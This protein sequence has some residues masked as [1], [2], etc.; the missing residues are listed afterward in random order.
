VSGFLSQCVRQFFWISL[1][2]IF[3]FLIHSFKEAQAIL[4]TPGDLSY[5]VGPVIL[6]GHQMK[7]L[8]GVNLDTINVYASDS[9]GQIRQIPF[10]IDER[11][12]GGAY[13][14][15]ANKIKGTGKISKKD[16]LVF[17]AR[18]AGPKVS[19]ENF[20]FSSRFVQEVELKDLGTGKRAWVY[21]VSTHLPTIHTPIHYIQYDPVENQ[22]MGRTYYL[23]YSRSMQNPSKPY[24]QASHQAFA[25][26]EEGQTDIH[27]SYSSL[28]ANLLRKSKLKIEVGT[29]AD[30]MTWEIDLKDFETRE[31]G[32]IIGPI[33]AIRKIRLQPEILPG[34]NLK[35]VTIL[36]KHYDQFVTTSIQG[37]MNPGVLAATSTLKVSYVEDLSQ[38]EELDLEIR[39]LKNENSPQNA[40]FVQFTASQSQENGKTMKATTLW[41]LLA[42]ASLE[43]AF[44]LSTF[45]LDCIRC[46]HFQLNANELPA[47]DY[48]FELQRYF[49]INSSP[50][51]FQ[52]FFTMNDEPL[53]IRA[54]I[55]KQDLVFRLPR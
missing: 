30:L 23:S 53:R 44:F 52:S 41:R 29:L 39:K 2:I 36:Q 51:T 13:I 54:T 37:Q 26:S 34:L 32:H 27:Q 45:D 1:L 4:L 49:P 9:R 28:T 15:I 22:V 3:A 50:Q 31:V 10:Q 38:M 16:E 14:F 7:E 33:R 40:E 47:G 8:L 11:F 48:Q 12:P 46:F 43:K 6:S 5:R 35:G 55:I 42:D 19:L 21:I 24:W 25:W 18:D 20:T 17:M